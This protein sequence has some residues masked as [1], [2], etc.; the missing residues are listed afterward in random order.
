MSLLVREDMHKLW[1]RELREFW[2]RKLDNEPVA[3]ELHPRIQ[4]THRARSPL[5]GPF[6][7]K[8]PNHASKVPFVESWLHD[9]RS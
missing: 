8:L 4:P 1:L 3:E 6:V 5:H 7:S 2:V 9:R